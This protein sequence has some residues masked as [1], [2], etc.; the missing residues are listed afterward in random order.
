VWGWFG[1][2]LGGS[3]QSKG[4]LRTDLDWIS[5]MCC[6]NF[7]VGVKGGGCGWGMS[8]ILGFG[9]A[10]FGQSWVRRRR[11]ARWVAV[12]NV[13]LY[14][15]QGD[16]GSSLIELIR[17]LEGRHGGG[18]KR[19]FYIGHFEPGWLW[20]EVLGN[21]SKARFGRFN[22]CRLGQNREDER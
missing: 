11:W 20:G 17:L 9:A 14:V 13:F 16:G 4:T 21:G 8:L 18:S 6:G 10:E 19:F 2:L 15:V 22:V 5:W 1:G 12:G 3:P 7:L